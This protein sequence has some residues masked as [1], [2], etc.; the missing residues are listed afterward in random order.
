MRRLALL[1]LSVLLACGEKTDAP[2][3]NE[4]PVELTAFL[5]R[6]RIVAGERAT[7]RVELEHDLDTTVDL[8]LPDTE[9]SEL[10]ITRRGEVE[11]RPV[12]NRRRYTLWYE[13]EPA[14]VGVVFLPAFEA[15]VTARD[16]SS[17][18][19][20]TDETYLQIVGA[21]SDEDNDIRDIRVPEAPTRI[22]AWVL[23]A[24]VI[25]LSLAGLLLV[26]LLR[27]R[28]NVEEV[29]VDP[30]K[31]VRETLARLTTLDVST[32]EGARNFCFE[33]TEALKRYL[34]SLCEINATDLTTQELAIAIERTW[35]GHEQ[36]VDFIQILRGADWIK[37]AGER[38]DVADL[39]RLLQM[40]TRFVDRA[41]PVPELETEEVAP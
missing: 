17:R 23:A 9:L 7:F 24:A 6:G 25:G 14:G 16:E 27:R 39:R 33:L 37:F 34:E 8:N 20:R 41:R 19:L 3:R 4:E 36:R 5:D 40:A 11:G 29:V 1:T 10:P 13:L 28:K 31:Q 15:R 26:W 22:P 38:G 12:P 35:L 2:P 32:Q 21:G 30:E 18:T